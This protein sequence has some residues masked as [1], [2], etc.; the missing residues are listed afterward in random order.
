MSPS[1]DALAFF[2][3]PFRGDDGGRLQIV[4]LK[5]KPVAQSQMWASANGVAW[6]PSG[7]EVLLTASR[8]GAGRSLYSMSRSGAIRV[9]AK[10]PGALTLHDVS[11][12]GRILIS[13]D[14]ANL[15]MAGMIGGEHHER[16][17]SWFDW[18]RA[19]AI[20]RDGTTL[21]FDESGEGAGPRY[22]TFIRRL[23]TGETIKFGEGR[24]MALSDDGKLV[25]TMPTDDN[26]SIR[27]APVAPGTSKVFGD[28]KFRYQAVRFFPDSRRLLVTGSEDDS[29]NRLY[30]QDLV[31][32]KRTL[33][34]TDMYPATIMLSPDATRMLGKNRDGELAV[35]ALSERQSRALPVGNKAWTVGWAEDPDTVFVR[36]VAGLPAVISRFELSTGRLQPWNKVAP[37]NTEGV[38]NIA[39]LVMSAAG[40]SYAY[41]YHRTLSE[42]YIVDGWLP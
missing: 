41:S 17:L 36:S 16:D 34:E 21:L 19:V 42:L 7:K 18:S 9:L 4:D 5:G 22:S 25:A 39:S 3:H 29:G 32:G 40:D 27:V 20:S 2:D 13:R 10:V 12:A 15:A 6:A 38:S 37:T 30:I 8:A 23:D 1:G 14:N 33:V 31:D 28:G 26:R 24:A 11:P 35:Q